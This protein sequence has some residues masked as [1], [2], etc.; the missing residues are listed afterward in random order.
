MWKWWNFRGCMTAFL[1]V[2]EKLTFTCQ[3]V[4]I[5]AVFTTPGPTD[6]QIE[7]LELY[8]WQSSDKIIPESIV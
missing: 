5:L 8:W 6:L 4:L 2:P 7:F 1:F 3:Y